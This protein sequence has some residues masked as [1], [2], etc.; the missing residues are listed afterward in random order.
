MLY[1]LSILQSK[2]DGFESQVRTLQ[3]APEANPPEPLVSVRN[4]VQ[5][6]SMRT[7]A[8]STAGLEYNRNLQPQFHGSPMAINGTGCRTR[9]S[10]TGVF[11]IL[12]ILATAFL[13]HGT[14]TLSTC[15]KPIGGGPNPTFET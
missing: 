3:R 15:P 6:L 14:V 2:A 7:G 9:D 5:R 13:I 10:V 1:L 4:R 8:R 11:D 12:R